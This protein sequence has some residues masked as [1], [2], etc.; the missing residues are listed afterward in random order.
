[1]EKRAF[2]LL[3][4]PSLLAAAP[5]TKTYHFSTPTIRDGKILMDNTYIASTA[6][7]PSVAVHAVKL[8]IPRGKT[9]VSYS[10]EYSTPRLLNGT[11]DVQPAIPPTPKAHGPVS[12]VKALGKVYVKNEFFPSRTSG[13][14]DYTVQYTNGIPLFYTTIFPTQYNAL[15]RQV[16]Y[17]NNIT[18][19][20]ETAP[21]VSEPPY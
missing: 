15:S 10:V 13:G 18:I 4:L 14:S 2:F 9:V 3:L 5:I 6:C 7:A 17:Y 1:M 21:A 8:L 19:K 11:Y 20:V 12:R 16:R